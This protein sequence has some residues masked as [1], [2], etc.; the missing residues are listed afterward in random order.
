MDPDQNVTTF[1]PNDGEQAAF[2]ASGS[3]NQ[4]VEKILVAQYRK[5]RNRVSVA[6]PSLDAFP[7]VSRRAMK[8]DR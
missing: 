2:H 7:Q 5:L 8:F 3:G 1:G 6:L 4:L